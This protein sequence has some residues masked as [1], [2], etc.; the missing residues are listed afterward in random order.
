MSGGIIPSLS[1]SPTFE[2]MSEWGRKISDYFDETMLPGEGGGGIS[3]SNMQ[4][5][6]IDMGYASSAVNEVAGNIDGEY[7][8]LVS[9]GAGVVNTVPHTLGRI[10]VGYV[11][12]RTIGGAGVPY[13][14]STTVH[15][16][17]N[18]YVK[19]DAAAGVVMTLLVF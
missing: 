7:R 15:T 13:Q 5:G 3:K 14:D 6:G 1:T 4:R 16:V 11:P 19:T 10:P 18:L 9:G 8:T 2:E 17:S 12:V